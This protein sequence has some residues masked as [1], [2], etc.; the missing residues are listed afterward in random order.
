MQAGSWVVGGALGVLLSGTSFSFGRLSPTPA[1][2]ARMCCSPS[3]LV[4][5]LV[6]META[7]RELNGPQ[8]VSEWVVG[9]QAHGGGWGMGAGSGLVCSYWQTIGFLSSM[10]RSFN[11]TAM[12][13]KLCPPGRT[14]CVLLVCL[15]S[16]DT[17]LWLLLSL[18]TVTTDEGSLVPDIRKQDLGRK[19]FSLPF[20]IRHG[21]LETIIGKP[22]C[23][24]DETDPK[25]GSPRRGWLANRLVSLSLCVRLCL[26]APFG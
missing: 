17:Q 2:Q 10:Q 16:T 4:L 19:T 1:S 12:G 23:V 20:W 5:V 14:D 15:F 22:P 3:P 18:L 13:V 8:T 25:Q 9:R 21:E 11:S 7:S 6:L 26:C 24:L